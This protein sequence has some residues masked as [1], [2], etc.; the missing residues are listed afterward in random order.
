MKIPI[1]LNAEIVDT[2]SV[3]KET[4]KRIVISIKN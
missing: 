1:S 2:V 4:Y 3:N